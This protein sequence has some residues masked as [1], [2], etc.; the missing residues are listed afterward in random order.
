MASRVNREPS[1]RRVELGEH[2]FL[3]L[4]ALLEGRGIGDALEHAVANYGGTVDELASDL[5][6]WFRNWS[7]AGYFI[8]LRG[9]QVSKET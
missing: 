2:E 7:A 6:R 9:I 5:Q 3:V 8:G 1:R 4:T